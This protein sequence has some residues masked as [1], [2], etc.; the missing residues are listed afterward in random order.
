MKERADQR[1]HQNGIDQ[2]KDAA[3]KAALEA[4]E[5]EELRARGPENAR[6]AELAEALYNGVNRQLGCG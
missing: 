6:S 2:A 1:E 4:K 5:A 3:E